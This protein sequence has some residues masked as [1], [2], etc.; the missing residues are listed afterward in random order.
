MSKFFDKIDPKTWR[1]VSPNLYIW[2]GYD[3][4]LRLWYATQ[5]DAE[6]NQIAE[7]SWEVDKY[8]AIIQCM[9]FGREF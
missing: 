6:G 1:E 8:D 9:K 3:K 4:H 7:G 5:H 2:W